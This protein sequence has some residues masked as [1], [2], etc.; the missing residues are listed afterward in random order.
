MSYHQSQIRRRQSPFDRNLEKIEAEM[1]GRPVLA[2]AVAHIE[3]AKGCKANQYPA[4]AQWRSNGKV[5]GPK[6]GVAL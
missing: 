4:G 5:Y 1:R 3:F 6:E 2:E